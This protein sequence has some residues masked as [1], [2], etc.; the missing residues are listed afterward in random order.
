MCVCV[1][2]RALRPESEFLRIN[3]V[4]QVSEVVLINIKAGKPP[5]DGT[6]IQYTG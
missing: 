2:V 6:G 1:C 5:T 4:E 3:P